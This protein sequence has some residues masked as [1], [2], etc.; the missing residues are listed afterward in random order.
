M[1]LLNRN[2]NEL[3]PK[4][5]WDTKN[6]PLL[7]G[8]GCPLNCIYCIQKSINSEQG[9][10]TG[11]ITS[12]IDGGISL[13]TRLMVGNTVVREISVPN[14]LLELQKYPYYR[15]ESSVIIENFNDP[16][17]NWQTSLTIAESL[18][19]KFQHTGPIIFITKLGITQRVLT[20]LQHLQFI[21]GK[22][23][24]IVTY[25]NLP[26]KIEPVSIPIRLNNLRHLRENHIPAILSM[27]PIISGIN[28]TEL[29]IREIANEAAP[30]ADAI[31]FGGL[32]VYPEIL[33]AFNEAGYFLDE[34]YT[35]EKY[36]MEKVILPHVKPMINQVMADSGIQAPVYEHTSCAVA[37]LLT[38]FYNKPS[39]DRMVHWGNRGRPLFAACS[40]CPDI[41]KIQCKLISE[42]Q[43]D[44]AIKKA[45]Y[46]LNLIGYQN[47]EIIF[48]SERAALFAQEISLTVGEQFPIQEYVGWPVNSLPTYEQLIYRSKNILSREFGV[49]PSRLVGAIMVDVEWWIFFDGDID[50]QNNELIERWLRGENRAWIRVFNVYDIKDPD[51]ENIFLSSMVNKANGRQTPIELKEQFRMIRAKILETK[52]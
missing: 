2:G 10:E 32:F 4:E 49:L 25:A 20:G 22:P 42:I 8:A 39:F 26:H 47:P 21:G 36:T 43:P 30:Y 27:R 33:K 9:R 31:I 46:A 45:E 35:K 24:V 48:S 51:D 29:S 23:I 44:I 37:Y 34:I 7:E 6:S 50:G 18:I 1:L 19:N 13:N 14:L 52:E 40:S 28:D 41:Q 15:K 38:T 16:G 17:V 12:D 11:Y 5:L 3:K